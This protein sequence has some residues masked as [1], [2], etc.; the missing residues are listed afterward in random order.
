MCN[1]YVKLLIEHTTRAV[2]IISVGFVLGTGW[3]LL[4]EVKTITASSN[5]II[6]LLVIFI[7]PYLFM[8]WKELP[9]GLR[10]P[11]WGGRRDAVQPE[12]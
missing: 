1:D 9:N 11:R 5:K 8:F 2:S 6:A 3:K 12:K 10:Y 7:F 4:Q